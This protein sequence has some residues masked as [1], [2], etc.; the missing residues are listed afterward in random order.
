MK[1]NAVG[2]KPVKIVLQTTGWFTD[3][4]KEHIFRF[5]FIYSTIKRM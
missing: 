4:K 1:Q 2:I 5:L 3:N